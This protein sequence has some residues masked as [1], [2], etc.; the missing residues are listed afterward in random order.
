MTYGQ[1]DTCFLQ[2]LPECAHESVSAFRGVVISGSIRYA[3]NDSEA[4]RR[5]TA[6][7]KR[8]N[9]RRHSRETCDRAKCCA[10]AY[11]VGLDEPLQGLLPFG[12]TIPTRTGER[13]FWSNGGVKKTIRCREPP[14]TPR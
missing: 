6:Q 11:L 4:I 13:D 14:Y 9:E 12:D 5:G 3:F 1:R 10:P 2:T 8:V 7:D